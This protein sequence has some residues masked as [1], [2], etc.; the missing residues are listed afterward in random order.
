MQQHMQHGTLQT[1]GMG[2]ELLHK[3]LRIEAEKSGVRP[4][5]TGRQ[6]HPAGQGVE[7]RA[8]KAHRYAEFRP[9]RL[10]DPS[11]DCRQFFPVSHV[12]PPC[13]SAV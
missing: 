6:V 3:V 4:D 11:A 8:E 10:Q 12:L 2:D 7:R 13:V 9:E 1:V 5:G